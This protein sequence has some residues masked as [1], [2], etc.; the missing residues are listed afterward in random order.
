MMKNSGN[1]FNWELFNRMPIIGILRDIRIE[2]AKI[3]VPL[4]VQAGFTN[5]EITI[6][7]EGA[8]TSIHRLVQEFG[9]KVNIGAGTVLDLLDLKKALDAGANFIVT[10]STDEEVIRACAKEGIPIFPG[11][12]TPTE[13]VK[14]WQLGATM[15]KVFPAEQLGLDYIKALKAPLKQIKL[16]PTGGIYI[17]N[18]REYFHAGVHGL[19][20]SSGLFPSQLIRDKDWKGLREHLHAFYHTIQDRTKDT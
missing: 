17:G 12:F 1:S 20:I 11:A 18:V 10:P 19:G 2:D 5:I 9:T 15:V 4:Y 7:S 3:I 16:L 13:I 14:A 8:E 6:N